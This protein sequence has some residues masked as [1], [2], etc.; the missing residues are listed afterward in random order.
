MTQAPSS[1]D[2]RNL[3]LSANDA[4]AYLVGRNGNAE[5]A[6]VDAS[7]QLGHEIKG[8][9]LIA[10]IASDPTSPALLSQQLRMLIVMQLFEAL[11]LAF[12]QFSSTVGSLSPRDS[13]LAYKNLLSEIHNLTASSALLQAPDPYEVVRRM[14][15]PEVADAVEHFLREAEADNVASASRMIEAAYTPSTPTL[16]TSEHSLTI[17][18]SLTTTGPE[19][20]QPPVTNGVDANTTST[21]T[22][23]LDNGTAS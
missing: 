1:T 12:M 22:P 3:S 6:A 13:A 10:I 20:A 9:H 8:A 18:P 17:A 23:T 2:Q 11:R 19:A 21:D 4:I 14:L 16:E 15:P 5:L 7:R